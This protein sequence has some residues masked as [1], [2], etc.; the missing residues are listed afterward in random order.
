MQPKNEDPVPGL[1]QTYLTGSAHFCDI[2]SSILSSF[3]DKKNY[4]EQKSLQLLRMLGI[5]H[6]FLGYGISYMF[7]S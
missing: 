3:R 2:M 7:Q 6:T 4:I 5:P 1:V